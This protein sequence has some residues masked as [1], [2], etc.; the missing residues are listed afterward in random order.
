VRA[1][2][3]LEDYLVRW[4]KTLVVVSHAREFLNMV[5]TDI[6]HL[7][8]SKLVAYKGNFDTFE[9][10]MNERLKNARKAAESQDMKRK[11]IQVGCKG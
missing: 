1:V 3:W 6:L 9:K 10:T 4:P 11:H 7:H 5:C 8:G 2:L